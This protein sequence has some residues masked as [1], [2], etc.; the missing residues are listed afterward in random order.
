MSFDPS[1]SG[2]G[3]YAVF[4]SD[5]TNLATGG[6]G[7]FGQVYRADTCL[8]VFGSGCSFSIQRVSS[9][10]ADPSVPGNSGS[11][12]P[13]ISFDGRYVAY[14]TSA[15]NVVPS[16]TTSVNNVVFYDTSTSTTQ[17][18]NQCDPSA[19]S[20][21]FCDAD[22]L[23]YKSMTPDGRYVVFSSFSDA[24]VTGD[25]NGKADVFRRDL[26]TGVTGCIPSTELISLST[27]GAQGNDNS[28]NGAEMT[29]SA[30]GRYVAFTSN[31]TNLA[32]GDVD[33]GGEADVFVRDT[34]LGAPVGCTPTT[35]SPSAFLSAT[36]PTY[37]I[38]TLSISISN[39]GRYV[40]WVYAP[41]SGSVTVDDRAYVTDL[42]TFTSPVTYAVETPPVGTGACTPVSQVLVAHL[43]GDGQF[44]AVDP[45]ILADSFYLQAY[46]ARNK[47]CP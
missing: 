30:D 8:G 16:G 31:A 13:S 36:Q 19:P 28:G 29:M 3:R 21:T 47:P 1:I 11:D 10:I 23:G 35:I 43:S 38:K 42:A 15:G 7:G 41:P 40:A 6:S 9:S 39:D 44:V 17:V 24:I 33:T 32:S 45:L 46:L 22:G 27:S 4:D 12:L 2:D 34:C 14:R 18:V 26:C 20:G 25:T 5:S 37:V